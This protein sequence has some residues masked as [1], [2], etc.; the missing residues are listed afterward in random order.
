MDLD[1]E[2]SAEA[3]ASEPVS[4]VSARDLAGIEIDVGDLDEPSSDALA[5]ETDAPGEDAAAPLEEDSDAFS[6]QE[7][8]EEPLPAEA[9]RAPERSGSA[10]TPARVTADLEEAD[11]YLQQGMRAEARALYERVLAAVPNHPKALLR[12][13]ELEASEPAPEVA[14]ARPAMPA[15]AKPAPAARPASAAK[16]ASP[17]PAAAPAPAA[18]APTESFE[19]ALDDDEPPASE[20]EPAP[21]LVAQPEAELTAPSLPPVSASELGDFDL[22][23]E[24]SGAMGDAEASH[25]GRGTESEA[26]EEVFSA[27][28]AGVRREVDAGDHEAHYDLGIAYKEMG[29][30]DDAIGEFRS[31]MASPE[32]SISCLHL[33]ALC[34]LELGRASD[35]IAHLEQALAGATLPPDQ[36]MALRLDLGRAYAAAGDAARARAAYEAVR[37]HDPSFGDVERL[38]ADLDQSPEREPA[39]EAAQGGL[40]SFDDLIESDAQTAAAPA[41]AEVYESFDDLMGDADDDGAPFKPP[42]RAPEA[43][44]SAA[45]PVHTRAPASAPKRAKPEREADA[46]ASAP[47][48]PA[49]GSRRKKKISFV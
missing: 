36:E 7:N 17:P 18:Q 30:L 9:P 40:E 13:G 15:P 2:P 26:F 8:D 49:P 34:A 31:A 14:P 32:R 12:M 47:A 20:P 37:A 39:G 1:G 48:K 35:A 5:S 45:P 3:G 27:F 33:M 21:P 28:K 44:R 19:L 41:A 10:T 42:A 29:L 38:L 24:L 6:F 16:P 11:F 25:A 23:A 46:E 43:P 4:D 22:A